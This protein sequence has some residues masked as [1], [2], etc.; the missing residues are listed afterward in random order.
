MRHTLFISDLHLDNS[1]P[2]TLQLFI[3]FTQNYIGD[4]VDALY[5]LGDLF[6][7]WVGDDDRSEFNEKIKYQL[8]T[9]T[10]QGIPLFF[11]HGNRDFLIGKQFSKETGCQL[12]PEHTV[13]TRYGKSI[14]LTHG[15]ALCTLDSKH[16]KFRKLT[17]NNLFKYLALFSPL[18]IRKRIG[19][20]LRNSSKKH[21]RAISNEMMD[22][23]PNT[24][25]QILKKHQVFNIVHGHTHQPAI[26]NFQ[27]DNKPAERIVLGSWEQQGCVLKWNENGERELIYFS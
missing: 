4:E 26:I 7:L 17:R 13:I 5:I 19:R 8:S 2:M 10:K 1:H 27:L 24:V 21:T 22:V 16:M 12:L 3:N 23:E 20:N 9:I 15:D 25:N 6:E 11:I 18:G 14:L